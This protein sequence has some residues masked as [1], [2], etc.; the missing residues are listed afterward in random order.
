MPTVAGQIVITELMHDVT[1]VE[2]QG[3]WFEV[4]NPSTTVTYDLMNCVIADVSGLTVS[5]TTPFVMPPGSFKT[6]AISSSPG[7][8]P[9]FVYGTTIKFDNDNADQASIRCG[10]VDI[11]TFAYAMVDAQMGTAHSFSLDPDHYSAADNDVRAN[12]C[13]GV[14]A[15]VFGTSTDY[16]TPGAANPQCP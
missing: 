7:F 2:D 13:L 10:S 14:T 5:I 8:T 12:W 1:G 3:E 16:G 9:D 15:Y 4:Y 11:D 6:L